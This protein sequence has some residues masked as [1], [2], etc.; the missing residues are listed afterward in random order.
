MEI[1]GMAIFFQ[2][3]GERVLGPLLIVAGIVMLNIDRISHGSGSGR[4]SSLGEKVAGWGLVGGFLLGV[5]FA[6]A[7]CPYSAIMFFGVLIPLALKSSGG[8]MLP[9]AFAIGTGLP[10]VIIGTLIS[11]GVAGISSWLNAI[12]RAEKIIRIIVSVVF[13]GVGL[14]YVVL[15]IQS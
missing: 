11:L 10:V 4:L 7:F 15:W 14:Y 3:F 1:P 12:T 6:L 5:I 8:I 9:A 13:I 2:D